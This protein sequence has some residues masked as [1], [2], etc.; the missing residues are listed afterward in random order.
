MNINIINLVATIYYGVKIIE[1]I[2]EIIN[3]YKWNI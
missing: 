3:I 2:L 1:C